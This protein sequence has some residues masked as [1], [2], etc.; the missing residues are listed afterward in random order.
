MRPFHADDVEGVLA[1]WEA[2]R[3]AGG[4]PVY[5]LAEVLASCEKDHAVVAHEAG[6]VVG[7]VVGRAAHAQGWVVFLGTAPGHED[8][9]PRLLAALERELTGTG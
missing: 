4:E 9:G 6:R 8:L 7:A 3:H 5:G 2:A 1:L